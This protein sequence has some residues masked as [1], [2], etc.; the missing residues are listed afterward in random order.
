MWLSYTE[1]GGHE[2][3]TDVDAVLSLTEVVGV[4][5]GVDIGGDFVDAWE[6]VEYAHVGFTALEHGCGEDAAVFDTLVFE[7]VGE[8]F[9]LYTGHVDDVGG[10]DDALEVGVLVVFEAGIFDA[11]FDG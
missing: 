5:C 2:S 8:T 4:G 1:D 3:L 9:A 10:G 7:G 11:H 6:R